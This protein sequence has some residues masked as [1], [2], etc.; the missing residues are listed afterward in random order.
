MAPS[1]PDR[2]N[3]ARAKKQAM[4][5]ILNKHRQNAAKGRLFFAPTLLLYRPG[6]PFITIIEFFY[7]YKNNI[8]NIY[9]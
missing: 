3:S 4:T 5:M 7:I 2:I 8:K 9:G 1:L 6:K